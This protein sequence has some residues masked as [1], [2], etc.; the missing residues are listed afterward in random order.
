M[1]INVTFKEIMI[2][3]LKVKLDIGKC[4]T[5]VNDQTGSKLKSKYYSEFLEFRGRYLWPLIFKLSPSI[6]K[7]INKYCIHR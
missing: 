5:Y 3:L 1:L 6:N 7:Y 4:Y 2:F